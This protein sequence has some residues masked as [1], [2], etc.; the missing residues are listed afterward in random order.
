[1]LA[2]ASIVRAIEQCGLAAHGAFTLADDERKGELAGVATLAL[3]GLGGRFG[4][5]A[6]TVSPE[7]EDGAGD[8]LDRWGRRVVGGLATELGAHALC[9]FDGPPHWSFQR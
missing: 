6:F 3:V 7:A 2:W 1:M 4:W 9:P 5:A 8:P